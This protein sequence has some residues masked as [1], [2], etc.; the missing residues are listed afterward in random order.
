[1][2]VKIFIVFQHNHIF[3]SKT[4]TLIVVRKTSML[5]V[6]PPTFSHT[7][8]QRKSRWTQSNVCVV[9][10]GKSISNAQLFLAICIF[11]NR[12]GKMGKWVGKDSWVMG[13]R[14]EMFKLNLCSSK[15][16]GCQ[17][18]STSCHLLLVWYQRMKTTWTWKEKRNWWDSTISWMVKSM[19]F[20]NRP[21][22]QA[23]FLAVWLQTRY[24]ISL[25][26]G[27]LIYE[28]KMIVVS[29]S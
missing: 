10:F 25:R 20:K 4:L 12:K 13:E 6:L 27:F 28:T 16:D 17:G 9:Y 2:E 24:L 18:L 15:H 7:G 3:F 5:P 29:S 11:Q 8:L 23:Q 21:G 19:G 1:M 26:L 14:K 22:I